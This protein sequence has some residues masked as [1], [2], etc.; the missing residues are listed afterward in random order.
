M[1]PTPRV[2]ISV[3]AAYAIESWTCGRCG[4]SASVPVA[5]GAGIPAPAL[6]AA[7]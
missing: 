6:R 3:D 1:S 2:T 5:A 4:E 7:A